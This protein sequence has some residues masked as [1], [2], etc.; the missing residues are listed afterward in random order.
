MT[1]ES[2]SKKTLFFVSTFHIR[3]SELNSLQRTRLYFALVYKSEC[4]I[5][6]RGVHKFFFFFFHAKHHR[7]VR[8]SLVPRLLFAEGENSELPI[9]FWFQYFDITM[10]SR[11]LDCEF[12][13]ALENSKLVV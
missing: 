5:F 6:V 4:G 9:L 10:M 7:D 11:Q 12:K 1:L 2:I 13:H 3:T 8:G